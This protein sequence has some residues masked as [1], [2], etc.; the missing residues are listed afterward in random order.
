V[1]SDRSDFD[2]VQGRF[3]AEVADGLWAFNER[4][5]GKNGGKKMIE[6]RF[7][8]IIE[9]DKEIVADVRMKESAGER[10]LGGWD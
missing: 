1:E 8:A 6:C 5:R 10:G 7:I 9:T 2:Q 4:E 3:R